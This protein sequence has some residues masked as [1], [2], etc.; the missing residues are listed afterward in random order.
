[1]CSDVFIQA[2]IACTHMNY[3][4]NVIK[5]YVVGTHLNC[6]NL[7]KQFKCVSTTYAIIKKKIMLHGLPSKAYEI[8]LLRAY[9]G[10]CGN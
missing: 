9:R 6:F 3:L 7:S 2:Y 8:A 4:Y 5:A 10:M 1:M